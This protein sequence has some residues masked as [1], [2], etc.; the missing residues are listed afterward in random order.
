MILIPRRFNV[1]GA[2][3]SVYPSITYPYRQPSNR[4]SRRAPTGN[5]LWDAIV[6]R[7]STQKGAHRVYDDTYGFDWYAVVGHDEYWCRNNLP[8][9]ISDCLAADDRVYGV[10]IKQMMFDGDTVII[11]LVI[12]GSLMGDFVGNIGG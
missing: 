1:A 3:E 12:N 9:L 7:L 6:K 2:G 10:Q 5:E 8:T 11:R 4:F